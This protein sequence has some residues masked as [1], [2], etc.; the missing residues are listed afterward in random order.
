MFRRL[1]HRIRTLK[2][3]RRG[4]TIIE[5]AIVAPTLVA[6]LLFI[7]DTGFY[8]YASAILGGEVNA[9]G[10][11][12][13]LETATADSRLAMD[14]KVKEQVNRLLISGDIQFQ[15]TAYKSYDRVQSKEEQYNDLNNNGIC[16]N[17]ESFDDANRNGVRDM[18]SGISGGGAARDVVVY[19]AT[20]TYTRMFPVSGV[21]GWDQQATITSSTLLRNQ[22]YDKQPEPLIGTCA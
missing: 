5:F 21:F 18:D 8:L 9:A 1:R 10:R 22:P 15:R 17:G 2:S 11:N 3:D 14:N 12:S 13:T 7:F 20:L 4:A 6:M 19:T 16:D